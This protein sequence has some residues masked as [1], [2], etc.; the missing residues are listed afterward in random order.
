MDYLVHIRPQ[1]EVVYDWMVGGLLHHKRKC[2]FCDCQMQLKYD[3]YEATY[4]FK[5]HCP[6]CM[7]ETKMTASTPMNGINLIAADRSIILYIEKCKRY[8]ACKLAENTTGSDFF[9]IIRKAT[10]YF[11]SKRVKKYI[12][13]D[14]GVNIDETLLGV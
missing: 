11:V 7:G 8:L 2:I 13:F 3:N 12:R 5:W 6:Y 4:D 10:A 1:I 14:R 9:S